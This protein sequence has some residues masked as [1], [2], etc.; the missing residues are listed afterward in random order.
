MS[1]NVSSLTDSIADVFDSDSFVPSDLQSRLDSF[2]TAGVNTINVTQFRQQIDQN[3]LSFNV[4]NEIAR[5]ASLR[6]DLNGQV[7]YYYS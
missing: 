2:T 4:T 7:G 3:I 1:L 6:S 5:L